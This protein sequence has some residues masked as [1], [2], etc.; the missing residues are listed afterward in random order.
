[1]GQSETH[2]KQLVDFLLL[3]LAGAGDELQGIKEEL[4]K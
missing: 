4:W 2:V 1:M 3:V